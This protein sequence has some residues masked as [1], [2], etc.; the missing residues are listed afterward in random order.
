MRVSTLKQVHTQGLQSGFKLEIRRQRVLHYKDPP[1]QQ[2]TG[3]RNKSKARD[4]TE[5]GGATVNYFYSLEVDLCRLL[6]HSYLI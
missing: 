1:A 3:C 2:R 4:T 5:R 6:L